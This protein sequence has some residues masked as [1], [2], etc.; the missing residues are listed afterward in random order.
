MCFF[1]EIKP[2]WQ[3]CARIL[4]P[5]GYLMAGFTN[6]VTYTF[7]FEKMS[8]GEFVMQYPLPYSDN[9]S[10]P[11]AVRERFLHPG[12]PREFSHTLTDI[13]GGL[14]DAGFVM[15]RFLE[16]EW[17][18]AEPINRFFPPFLA[19]RARLLR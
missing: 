19:I 10:L 14:L 7:D 17:E 11:A 3:E 5:G 16:D 6:P 18:P 4:R 15:D 2:V 12:E 1:P 13:I 9:T 8:K